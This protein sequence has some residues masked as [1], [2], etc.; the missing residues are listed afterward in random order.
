[1]SGGAPALCQVMLDHIEEFIRT[2]APSRAEAL[3]GSDAK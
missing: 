3:T 1:M 2:C